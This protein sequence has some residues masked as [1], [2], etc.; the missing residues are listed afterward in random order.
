MALST[1]SEGVPSVMMMFYA[2]SNW[3]PLVARQ[4]TIAA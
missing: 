1:S 4:K 3:S 2:V